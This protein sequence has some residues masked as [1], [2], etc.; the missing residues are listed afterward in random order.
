MYP[1]ATPRRK[2]ARCGVFA[3]KH[4]AT[5]P[6]RAAMSELGLRPALGAVLYLDIPKCVKH[7]EDHPIPIRRPGGCSRDRD[8]GAATDDTTVSELR[9]NSIV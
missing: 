1:A 9:E 7:E 3:T 2:L 8:C 4:D 5:A 6:D